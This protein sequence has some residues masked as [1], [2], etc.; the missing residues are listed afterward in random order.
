MYKS[1]AGQIFPPFCNDCNCDTIFQQAND[2][3]TKILEKYG[4]IEEVK[5]IDA[6]SADVTFHS[7]RDADAMMQNEL[8]GDNALI[9]NILLVSTWPQ[10][11]VV[12]Q[13]LDEDA[14]KQTTLVD[15][16]DDCL[17]KIFNYC[18]WNARAILWQTCHRTR[19]LLAEFVL[20]K[21]N[22][23]YE[24]KWGFPHD[25]ALVVPE[26]VRKDLIYIGSH[27][28][29]LRLELSSGFVRQ[30]EYPYLSQIHEI[31]AC[32]SKRIGD[33]INEI[34]F[35][36]LPNCLDCFRQQTLNNIEKLTI[37][38][39]M[40]WTDEIKSRLPNLKQL[41]YD[42]DK[43]EK[44]D[45]FELDV[46]TSVG[47]ELNLIQNNGSHLET[48]AIRRNIDDQK[49]IL[50]SF[51]Q[52]N[53]KLKCLELT[54]AN[55]L[56]L[57]HTIWESLQNLE[58]LVVHGALRHSLHCP[59]LAGLECLKNLNKLSLK[60]SWLPPISIRTVFDS[61]IQ[62]K[63]LQSVVLIVHVDYLQE[64]L[65]EAI[66]NLSRELPNLEHFYI[67]CGPPLNWRGTANTI[68]T[69]PEAVIVEFIETARNLKTFWIVRN[70]IQITH[71][72]VN[73]LADIRKLQFGAGPDGIAV[74][75]FLCSVSFVGAR[76][77][78]R[79]LSLITF[80]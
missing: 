18:D 36:R 72:C 37:Y 70:E 5:Q 53:S 74:L 24:I 64:A 31:V 54:S 20:S 57:P 13:L 34:E 65:T 17:L 58:E 16:N 61:I 33:A 44:R 62:L 50:E 71:N 59:E 78:V 79:I 1:N 63:K 43:R 80:Q 38:T 67:E 25:Q 75:D 2:E 39:H 29:K 8:N 51:L 7:Y 60:I 10:P 23:E 40:G 21:E 46:R 19:D 26:R 11:V 77:T 14:P 22:P 48:L 4:R 49:Q 35:I 73:S 66:L 15:L 52:D 69:L 41:I 32:C 12:D 9:A 30:Y 28:K 6:F 68:V 3:F 56:K 42:A 45:P 76:R 47:T 27:V 55:Y